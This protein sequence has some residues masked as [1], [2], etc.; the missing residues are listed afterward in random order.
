MLVSTVCVCLATL[1]MQKRDEH[2]ARYLKSGATDAD[3]TSEQF[4]QLDT[5]SSISVIQA[6]IVG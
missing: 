1:Y 5:K 6:P 3:S 2:L 4:E